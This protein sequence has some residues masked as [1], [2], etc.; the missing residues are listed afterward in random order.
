M[1]SSTRSTIPFRIDL[2]LAALRLTTGAIFVAHGAQK[3]F[4]YGFGGVSGAFGGMHIP[5]PGITGPLT[6]LVEFFGGLALVFGLL[7]RLAGFGLAITMLG[8][9]AF[10]HFAN[11]F[12]APTGFEYP[13]A[14]LG[15]NVAVAL[16]GAGRFSLDALIARR[17]SLHASDDRTSNRAAQRAA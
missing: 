10:V 12:F 6:G 14:L 9:I 5:A 11:G 1:T 13:L 7:T 8:A 3:L 17:R 2:A 4:V 16:A 15:A